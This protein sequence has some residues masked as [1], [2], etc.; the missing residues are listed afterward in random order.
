MSQQQKNQQK[1]QRTPSFEGCL[2]GGGVFLGHEAGAAFVDDD[3]EVRGGGGAEDGAEGEAGE[4]AED[5]DDQRDL[6]CPA[7]L[8]LLVL[9]VVRRRGLGLGVRRSGFGEEVREVLFGEV[10]RGVNDGLAL[11]GA[12]EAFEKRVLFVDDGVCRGVGEA[13]VVAGRV[14]VAGV[15]VVAERVVVGVPGLAVGR[16]LGGQDA[17]GVAAPLVGGG[18]LGQQFQGR[19]AE[20]GFAELRPRRLR[21]HPVDVRVLAVAG[22]A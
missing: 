6:G 11:E 19:D 15:Q 5:R 4:G 10:G 7:G 16:V 17:A 13:A 12:G 1:K 2:D 3:A 18:P 14:A 8:L 9:L 20:R 21:R 22:V